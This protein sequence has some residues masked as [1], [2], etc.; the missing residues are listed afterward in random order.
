LDDELEHGWTGGLEIEIGNERPSTGLGHDPGARKWILAGV[1]TSCLLTAAFVLL[2]THDVTPAHAAAIEAPPEPSSES[3]PSDGTQTA[4]PSNK[5]DSTLAAGSSAAVQTKPRTAMTP[6]PTRT[7]SKPAVTPKPTSTAP[8]PTP[9]APKPA[10]TASKPAPAASK[11]AGTTK[12]AAPKSAPSTPAPVEWDETPKLPSEPSPPSA[13]GELP[14]V[15]PWDE[16]DD[17]ASSAEATVPTTP[18]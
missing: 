7:A 1:G 12:P 2:A 13:N 11:P 3:A 4:E 14:D 18:S 8:N 17:E 9:T 15:E 16:A 10:P 5:A 6:K